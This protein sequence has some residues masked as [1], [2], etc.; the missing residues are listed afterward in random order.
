MDAFL[1][2]SKLLCFKLCFLHRFWRKPHVKSDVAMAKSINHISNIHMWAENSS[3]CQ[4]QMENGWS[5]WCCWFKWP[6]I[7]TN[8]Q[9]ANFVKSGQNN[10]LSTRWEIPL[11]SAALLH[12]F[13][14]VSLKLNA[15]QFPL[16]YTPC[17]SLKQW[18]TLRDACLGLARSYS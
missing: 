8:F 5:A 16:V 6:G 14:A 1:E 13:R 15:C 7:L 2:I 3:L 10:L 12:H 4:R 17:N 9:K 11:P 18:G